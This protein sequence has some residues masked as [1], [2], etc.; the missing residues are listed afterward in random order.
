[1]HATSLMPSPS[2]HIN[3]QSMRFIDGP[4]TR[5]YHQLVQHTTV[6]FGHI[7]SMLIQR[8]GGLLSSDTLPRRVAKPYASITP[9]IYMTDLIKGLQFSDIVPA[10]WFLFFDTCV[11]PSILTSQPFD[12]CLSRQSNILREQQ[13]G[14]G[15]CVEAHAPFDTPPLMTCLIRSSHRPPR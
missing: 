3:E 2:F 13:L 1:M 7:L 9:P 5:A 4:S 15:A 8:L 6:E 11:R 10:P 12:S 14:S